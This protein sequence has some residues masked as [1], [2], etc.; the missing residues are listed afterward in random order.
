MPIESDNTFD[1]KFEAVSYGT[2]KQENITDYQR[3]IIETVVQIH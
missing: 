1:H 2:P 3:K